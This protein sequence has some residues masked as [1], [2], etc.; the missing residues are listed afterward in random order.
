MANKSSDSIWRS[1]LKDIAR[2]VIPMFG[3]I[4]VGLGAIW[5]L[6][7]L[8][9]VLAAKVVLVVCIIVGFMLWLAS[10]SHKSRL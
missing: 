4:L 6:L 9:W 2:Y 5:I 3:G 8:H 1:V 7:D 10:A